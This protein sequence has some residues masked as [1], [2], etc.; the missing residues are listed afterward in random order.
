MVCPFAFIVLLPGLRTACTALLDGR[1]TEGLGRRCRG[2]RPLTMA[3]F[4]TL[5]L[6]APLMIWAAELRAAFPPAGAGGDFWTPD[7]SFGRPLEEVEEWLRE[8]GEEGRA[9]YRRMATL[10]LFAFCFAYGAALC[11]LLA[12]LLA[13]ENG[14][15]TSGQPSRSLWRHAQVLPALAVACDVVETATFLAAATM[16]PGRIELEPVRAA[17]PY[18][19]MVHPS[20]LDSSTDVLTF[21][22]P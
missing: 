9:V 6:L 12:N 10:D 7:S 2:G 3:T 21:N 15:L 18:F 1:L 5:A 11:S 22:K 19:N 17:C 14:C 4:A 20:R 16:F 13:A 8:A